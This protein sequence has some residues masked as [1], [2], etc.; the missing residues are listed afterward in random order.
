MSNSAF[1][2]RWAEV[3]IEALS[4]HGMKH[5]CIAPG[6]RSTPLTL[7]AINNAKLHCHTH[8]DERGLGHLALGLAKA[9]NEP[10][11]VIVT[12]GTAVAN[13]YPS[14]IEAGLTGEK[15]IFLTA[16]RPPELIDCGANQAIRQTHIFASHPAQ[17]LML[18]R[19]TQDISAKWLV[20]AIDNGMNQLRHGAFHINCPFAEPLYGDMDG[21]HEWQKTLGEWWNSSHPWLTEPLTHSVALV[22]DW[23]FWRQKKGVVLAG[24]MSASEGELV[25]KWAQELGW[26]VIGD[27]LSQTGQ[28]YPCAD[29]WLQH[30][31]AQQVL[32]HAELVVQFGSSLTGK[33]LLQW[34]ANCEPQEYWIIDSIPQ[35]LDP[36]NHRGRK[37]TCSIKGWLDN[38][39]AQPRSLWCESLQTLAQ[40]AQHHVH[41]QLHDQFSEAAVAFQLPELLSPRGQLFVGNSLIVRLVDALAQLP[42]GYPVYSNRGASGIDGLIS[43][44]AGV[45]R[46]TARPTL[47]IVGDISALYDLNSLALLR[48]P[49]APTVLIIVN[50]NGGQI[51]SMLPTPDEA[52]QNYYCMPQNV[53]FE[54]AAKMFGLQYCAPTDWG[55]LKNTVQQFWHSQQG[56][57]LV[58]LQVASDEGARTL[59]QLLNEVVE[60]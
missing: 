36:A 32:K 57:L 21:E 37:L 2:L 31:D 8:F 52:R 53:S 47:A 20:T 24:R 7:A 17:S 34:Q 6:S 14:L 33:R 45:Q 51:F 9:S 60:L 44:M 30:P 59:K 4:R 5:I 35:R 23:Y 13:L 15:V 25:A 58:E 41:Q 39:P 55:T 22:A 19:P 43:T 29:L 54:P 28:P 1:N 26:P 49:S 40:K 16:D 38:H 3:I 50:N 46:A 10:V 12:S 48:E 56:T 42:L 27:V 11:G 18:P